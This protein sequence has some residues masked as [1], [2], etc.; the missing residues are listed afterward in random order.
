M[1][2]IAAGVLVLVGLVWIAIMTRT[3]S[4]P[5][6]PTAS[7]GASSPNVTGNPGRSTFG[8][9]STMN[10]AELS[11]DQTRTTFGQLDAWG[12][13]T[14]G[15]VF[16]PTSEAATQTWWA[17]PTQAAYYATVD[18]LNTQI[19]EEAAAGATRQAATQTTLPAG[20][21]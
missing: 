18:A 20:T 4:V 5:A 12:T 2:W 11:A 17:N 8:P 16:D 14:Q 6:P 10:E 1:R 21:P 19:A 9:T 15:I 3:P 13:L 7:A